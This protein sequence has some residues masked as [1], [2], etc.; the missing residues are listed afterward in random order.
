MKKRHVPTFLILITVLLMLSAFCRTVG[1]VGFGSLGQFLY[2]KIQ[3]DA[4]A[5][6]E[7]EVAW[8]WNRNPRALEPRVPPAL[9]LA[10]LN[11]IAKRKVDIIVEVAHPD[12]T[13]DWGTKFV[14]W[15]DYFVGSP[16]AFADPT[17]EQALRQAAAKA[18]GVYI[19]S[20]ALWGAEDIAKMGAAGTLRGLR[21]TMKKHPASL[22][23]TPPLADRLKHLQT[24]VENVIY[25]GAV[26]F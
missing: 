10:D 20:G 4:R 1:I 19:P 2:D 6:A 3:T 18:N 8:V 24:G 21:V 14:E 25:E 9:R 11:E 12:I 22:K 7:L 26:P 16:T 5:S 17:V 13:K 15:S 23:L